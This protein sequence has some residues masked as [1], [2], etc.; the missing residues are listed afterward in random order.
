MGHPRLAACAG[1][2]PCLHAGPAFDGHATRLTGP[3]GGGTDRSGGQRFNNVDDKPNVILF[4]TDDQTMSDMRV[5]SAVKRRIGGHGTTFARAFSSYPQCCPAR[6]TL[7]TGQY[8]H[9]HGVMG[10]ATAGWRLP[11]FRR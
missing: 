11:G 7:L 6:A 4:L 9:N 5:L 3:R 2:D 8:A 10:N 1:G